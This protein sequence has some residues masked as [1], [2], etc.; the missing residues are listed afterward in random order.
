MLFS[1]Y[2]KQVVKKKISATAQDKK[3]WF[4]F[5]QKKE[6][7]YNKESE[8]A[9]ND[10]VKSKI[11][12]LKTIEIDLLYY[13]I[14]ARL[15]TTI[16]KSSFHAKEDPEDKY[17]SVSKNEA[18]KLLKKWLTINPIFFKNEIKKALNVPID[19]QVSNKDLI[20]KR[21]KYLS[22][23]YSLS[24]QSPIQMEKAAFQYMYDNIGNT[25]L[26]AYNNVPLVGHEHPKITKAGQK[27]IGILN[28]NTRYLYK[29]L[30][31]YSSLLLKKFPKK[32]TKIFFVNSG[33]AAS[34]LA[35][36]IAGVHTKNKKIA[37]I[38]QGYHGNTSLGID[39]SHYKYSRKGG[40]KK[41]KNIIELK[42]PNTYNNFYEKPKSGHQ[43]A[44]E[45]IQK[46]KKNKKLC[47]FIAE[48]IVGCA[49]Q[50]I[51]A[52]NYIKKIHPTIKKLGGVYIADETQ[53]GFGRLGKYFWGY[54]MHK[55]VPDIVIL[56]KHIGNGHPMAAVVTTDALNQSFENG[57]E[58]FS[59]FGGNP[60]SC[61]IGKEVLNII[62]EENLQQNALKVGEY[63]QKNL[64]KLK[65]S[66][67]VIDD[68][69]GCGLFIGIECINDKGEPGKKEAK[70]ITNELKKKFIL[71]STDGQFENVIKIKPPLCFTKKNA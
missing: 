50:V 53:T 41:K 63:L 4:N 56:G 46:L 51:I 62:E 52:K 37:V 42:L 38:E 22:K 24:Y 9:D 17:I 3:D 8:F 10:I 47:A 43:Y 13:L 5:T 27:Q 36:R 67:K 25:Y 59:S 11:T 60:V 65:N 28:T 49:G 58:F 16:L 40:H 33:S 1:L 55:I 26:D 18:V 12:K 39:I 20:K 48:P 2:I 34:D 14:A 54:E 45:A 30:T 6:K 19:K 29:N 44:I 66:Y 69:R 31:D 71:V 7:I 32:F 70:Y 61:E 35:I 64:I 68:V 21:K 57:M 23:S 15:C